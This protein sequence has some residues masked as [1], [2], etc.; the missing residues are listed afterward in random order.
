MKIIMKIVKRLVMALVLLYSVN[1][2]INV[3]GEV[4]PINVYSICIISIFGIPGLF[5][6]LFLKIFIL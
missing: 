4:I 6:L 1:L 3:S 5:A 2:I